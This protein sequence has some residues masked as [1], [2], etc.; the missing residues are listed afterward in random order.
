M[1][2][3]A[4]ITSHLAACKIREY[5]PEDLQACLAVYHSNEGQE[6]TS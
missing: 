6:L 5:T 2:L 1:S 4:P 3:L